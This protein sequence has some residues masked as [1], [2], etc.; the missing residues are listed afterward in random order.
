MT[1][2]LTVEPAG[3]A[4]ACTFLT[5]E[6]VDALRG[7]PGRGHVN[8]V[9]R[10]EG[11]AFRTCISIYRGRW[12]FVINKAMREA[13]LLPGE[14]YSVVLERDDTPKVAHPPPDL[15]AALKADAAVWEAWERTAMSRRRYHVGQIEGAKKPETR[16]RRIDKVVAAL[17]AGQKL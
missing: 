17:A 10:H 2:D 6:Q 5:Q 14:T 15:V 7:K 4:T 3:K 1:I 11:Q 12:M 8:L 16:Q 13:G 9:L